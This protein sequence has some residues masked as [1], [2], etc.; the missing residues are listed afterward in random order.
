M[1]DTGRL[2]PDDVVPFVDPSQ[3]D[4]AEVDRPDAVV[5]L[6]K[7]DGVLLQRVGDEEQFLLEPERPGV[8]D[9]LHDEMAGILDR[10]QDSGIGAR[11]GPVE[12]G[13]GT[14]PGPDILEL[15]EVASEPTSPITVLYSTPLGLFIA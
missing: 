1:G 9:A 7:A 8:R 11:G 5:H 2:R 13:R 3:Q 15:P 12:G 14:Q 6:L 10:G 4:A